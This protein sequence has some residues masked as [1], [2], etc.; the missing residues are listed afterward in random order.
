[1]LFNII[2]YLIPCQNFEGGHDLVG[3][4]C[5]GCFAGH[6][7]DECLEGDEAHSVGIHYAHDAGELVF[8]LW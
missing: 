4:V 2:L 1:M 3:G 6:K 7:V 5:V 8:T